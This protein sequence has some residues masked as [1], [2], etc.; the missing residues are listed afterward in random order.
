MSNINTEKNSEEFLFK[1]WEMVSSLCLIS[2]FFVSIFHCTSN[3]ENFRCPQC[4]WFLCS[5][6][7]CFFVF[8][9]SFWFFLRHFEHRNAGYYWIPIYFFR[10]MVQFQSVCASFIFTSQCNINT[11]SQIFLY[12]FWENDEVYFIEMV[13]QKCDLL[14]GKY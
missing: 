4:Y 2:G 6:T 9:N 12:I 10:S 11:L 3:S 5:C 14:I 7:S 1:F 13:Q 8:M